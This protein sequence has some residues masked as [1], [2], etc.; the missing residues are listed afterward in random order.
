MKSLAL[1]DQ[2]K[3]R[4]KEHHILEFP[5]THSFFDFLETLPLLLHF[6]REVQEES[7]CDVFKLE[8][9]PGFYCLQDRISIPEVEDSCLIVL[10]EAPG[11]GGGAGM[12]SLFLAKGFSDLVL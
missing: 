12:E 4:R 7:D 6:E 8:V 5:L 1:C 11:Y 10:R 9:T 3:S 2:A